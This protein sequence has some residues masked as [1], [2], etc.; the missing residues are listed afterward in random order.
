MFRFHV[1]RFRPLLFITELFGL[2]FQLC[3]LK[4][5]FYLILN[6]MTEKEIIIFIRFKKNV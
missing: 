4:L 5:E 1:R 2:L 3:L 6:T